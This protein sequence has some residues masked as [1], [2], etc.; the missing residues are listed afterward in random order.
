MRSVELTSL[1]RRLGIVTCVFLALV[2]FASG[3]SGL[4]IRTWD[5]TLDDRTIAR[6]AA[7]DVSDL[8]LAY[9]DQDTGIRGY[10]MTLDETFLSGN[11]SFILVL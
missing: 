2:I 5:R 10:L 8:R 3:L 7:T 9:S 1:R 6:N 11:T 4:M